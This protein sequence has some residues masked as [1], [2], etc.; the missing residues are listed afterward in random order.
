MA[1]AG[2]DHILLISRHHCEAAMKSLIPVAAALCAI[3]VSPIV[4][5]KPETS[6][7][8]LAARIARLVKQ[9]DAPEF[10]TR[11]KAEKELLKIGKPALEAVAQ[12]AKSPSAE[13]Q[14]RAKRILATINASLRNFLFVDLQSKGNLKLTDS[15]HAFE[16]NHLK[17]LPQGEQV[18]GGVKFKIGPKLVQLT[19]ENAPTFPEKVTGIR[20]GKAATQIH[21]LHAT[22]WGSPSM[23]DGTLIGSYIVHYADKTKDVIPIEYG[24]DVRD[25]WN[26]DDSKKCTRAKVVWTGSNPAADKFSDMAVSLRLYLGTWKNPHP[27]KTIAGID[28]TSTNKTICAPFCIAITLEQPK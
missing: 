1:D 27:K 8:K 23:A 16:G 4:A 3:W 24:R 5:Q 6:D 26:F 2:P 19:S 13:V 11:E 14:I 25:W 15:F 18:L 22:G 28:Y 12:A 20:V 9:L 17:K 21:F 10:E 7:A